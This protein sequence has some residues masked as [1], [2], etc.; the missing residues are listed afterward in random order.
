MAATRIPTRLSSR[1]MHQPLGMDPAQRV[2]AEVEL[3]GVVA[4]NDR[5]A[6]EPVCGHGAPRCAL[7]GDAHRIGRHLQTGD[8][9]LLEMTLPGGLIGKQALLMRG[10][11]PDDRSGQGV[12]AHV[13]QG[14][15]PRVRL[16]RPEGSLT[17][18]IVGV[19]GTQQVE[20]VQT[21]LAVR[22]AE[23]GECII[24]DV[25]CKR[26]WRRGGSHRCRPR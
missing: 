21:T 15:V 10:Q 8:A 7:G 9:E 3:P 4:D 13:V 20:E 23:L 1:N 26:R 6:Q 11:L 25:R 18:H 22:R 12:L 14:R 19:T 24:A 5:L 17:D 16:R 2:L